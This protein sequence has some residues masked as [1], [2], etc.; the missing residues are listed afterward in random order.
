M[1][2]DF[3]RKV[4]CLFG[5]PFDAVD[6]DTASRSLRAAAL[7]RTRCF[8]ST[9]NLNFVIA[10]QTDPA[11]RDSVLHSDLSVA[12]GMPLV[13]VARLLRI[14]LPERVPGSAL[15]ER[16]RAATGR[17]IEVFFFGGADG[18]A[19]RACGRLNAAASGLHC[20]GF[21]APGF[22]SVESMSGDERIA[23]IN[24]SGA[25]FVVVSLGARKGQA[26]IE[27][28]RAR[29]QAPLVSHLGAVVN[30]VA[31]TVARAPHWMQRS[32]LEWLWRIKEEP[33]L[34]RRYAG[35]AIAF[36]RLLAMQVFPYAV[37]VRRQAPTP[38]QLAAARLETRRRT[39]GLEIELHGAWAAGNVSPLRAV[40]AEA[41]RGGTGVFIHLGNVTH[42]DAAVV[43]L[44]ALLR[45][46]CI[47]RGLAFRIEPGASIVRKVF[48]YCGA[49]YLLEAPPASFEEAAC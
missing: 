4:Y 23:R 40:L 21:D 32:G 7:G 8:L 16:L 27:R 11:F 24:A 28:N 43:A 22:G 2:P 49:G 9:P 19:E 17:P 30:F 14:P 31:G 6:M 18:V 47:R 44:L 38:A 36:A 25:E 35:D 48:R 34:W 13:W 15:F 29:L 45:A 26:W 41:A 42:I 20:A 3:E 33:G 37:H 5:L 39:Q 10:A 46:H 12:D 1:T